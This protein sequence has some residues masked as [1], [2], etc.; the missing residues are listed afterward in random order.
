MQELNRPYTP[1]ET[2]AD[3]IYQTYLLLRT[4]PPNISKWARQLSL[5]SV[6]NCANSWRV[7]GIS[8]EALREIATAG[9]RTTQQRGHWFAREQRYATLFGEKTKVLKRDAFIKFFFEHDT[10]V[11]VT[12]KQNNE[13]GDHSTWGRIVQVPDGMFP[14]RGYVF[15]VRKRTEIPWIRDQLAKL[16]ATPRY[17]R[18]RT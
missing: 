13:G 2:T 3:F 15:G 9:K 14:A 11:I 12:K 10:T 5:E 4:A 17:P 16:D 6:A 18:R 8:E 7:I 1:D